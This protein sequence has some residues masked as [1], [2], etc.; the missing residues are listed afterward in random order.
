[1]RPKV[2]L[3]SILSA[4]LVLLTA[5]GVAL[6]VDVAVAVGLGWIWYLARLYH[7]VQVAP[8]GAA[9]AAVC[10]ILFAVGSHL[11]LGW[12]YRAVRSADGAPSA[13]DGER[14]KWRWTGSM[15]AVIVLMFVAGMSVVG[16]TH[17]LGWLVNSQEPWIISG[18]G[19]SGALA[20]AQSTNNLKQ[21][22]LALHWYHQAHESLPPGGTFDREGRPLES[23][24]A[25]ILPYLE[26]G[27]LYDRIEISVP[28]NH[29][30]N[31]PAF[32]TEVPQYLRPG[33]PATRNAA[34][35][36][37]SHYAANVYMLGGSRARTFNEV[38]DGKAST[39]MAGEVTADFKA[40]GDPTNW[41]DPTLG[42][43]SNPRGF[44][45]P[46]RG[47][48]TFLMVDGSVRF[49]KN[50]V[51]PKVLKALAT[52]AGGEKLSSDQY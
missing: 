8:D 31:A 35:Y 16:M 18:S 29:S 39:L 12:L 38:S 27:D 6:P 30:R 11:F 7:E 33:I 19:A 32:Q 28:W 5:M 4:A 24:Q 46:A 15:T 43:N 48:V 17:Q 51:D 49:I 13:P 47:G 21:I 25:M 20:R 2:L 22:G 23:W 1:M 50:S 34:G 36:A 3:I 9:T 41:R 44:A 26:A 37:V 45:S 40:W 10:L 14:W 42:L 52:P